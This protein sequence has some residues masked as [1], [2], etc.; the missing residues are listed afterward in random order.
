MPWRAGQLH[1]DVSIDEATT[2]CER[3][4]VCLVSWFE[5]GS[6]AETV[7]TCLFMHQPAFQLLQQ[8]HADLDAVPACGTPASLALLAAV[9]TVVKT[10]GVMRQLVLHAD[11]YEVRP[12]V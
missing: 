12:V 9:T 5:G 3:L 6:L 4:L 10:V 1:F 11:I 7:F 8:R 2:I